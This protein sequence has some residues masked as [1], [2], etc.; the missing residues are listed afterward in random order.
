MEKNHYLQLQFVKNNNLKITKLEKLQYS[1][2]IYNEWR[3]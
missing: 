2:Y 1:I 3:L